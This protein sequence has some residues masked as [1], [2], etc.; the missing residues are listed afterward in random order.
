[1]WLCVALL[2]K[3]TFPSL[4]KG[5]EVHSKP[6]IIQPNVLLISNPYPNFNMRHSVNWSLRLLLD[7]T[8][9]LLPF[10]ILIQSE[11]HYFYIVLISSVP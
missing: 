6:L 3:L 11:L 8:S 1:M 5:T 9:A 10:S 2:I 7:V 4:L